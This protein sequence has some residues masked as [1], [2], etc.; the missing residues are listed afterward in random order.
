MQGSPMQG[1]P[2]QGRGA[3]G[4]PPAGQV[5]RLAQSTPLPPP[6]P[7]NKHA[8]SPSHTRTN[9]RRRRAPWTRSWRG[10]ISNSAL[11]RARWDIAGGRMEG[12]ARGAW[13]AQG[14]GVAPQRAGDGRVR[15]APHARPE[16]HRA[17][18][19]GGLLT[20]R[21]PPAAGRAVCPACAPARR[22]ARVFTAPTHTRRSHSRPAPGYAEQELLYNKEKLLSLGDRWET[23]VAA[24]LRQES[25]YR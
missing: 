23:E 19:W 17:R 9:P 3:Q 24:N 4:A 7:P 22:A 21:R 14:G 25:L 5:L 13:G 6:H 16:A 8:L 18:P 2:M 15:A 10:P 1:S 20:A 11:R 12:A